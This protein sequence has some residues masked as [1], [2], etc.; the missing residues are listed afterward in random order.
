MFETLSNSELESI[1]NQFSVP[2]FIIERR[3]AGQDFQ[4]VGLNSALETLAG[5]TRSAIMGRSVSDMAAAGVANDASEYYLRCV[6][7]RSTVRFTYLFAHEDHEARWITTLQYTQSPEGYD[8]VIATAIDVPQERPMLQDRLAFEDVRYFSSIADL[9][10]E[11]LNSAFSS[12]RQAASLPQM[13]E[14]R[15]MRLHAVCRTVQRS[16]AD[17]RD[18]VKQA[19]I[20]HGTQ[21]VERGCCQSG[22]DQPAKCPTHRDTLAALQWGLADHSAAESVT[23]TA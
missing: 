14:E 22:K 15:I 13:Q 11:N 4:M 6:T 12:A 8:R 3:A 20:R 9:Q 18:I 21:D 17:I 1:L 5:Q 10:L 7:T 23:K 19:Q 16:V 2:M